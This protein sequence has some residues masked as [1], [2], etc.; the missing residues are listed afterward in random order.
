MM[1]RILTILVV[2]FMMLGLASSALAQEYYFA[3]PEE[4]VH[5]YWNE[6]GTLSLD[7]TF[8]FANQPGAHVIDFVDVGLPNSSFDFGSI[9][10]DVNGNAVSISRDY[11][12]SGSGV[13]VD[14][15]AHAIQPGQTGIVRVRVGLISKVLYTDSEIETDASAVFSPTWFG[16]QYVTGSTDLTVVF[17]LP[18]GVLPEEPRWHGAPSGFPTEP[19]TA[20]DDSGRVTYTWNN[21][22]ANAYTQYKFGASFPKNYVP[23]DVIQTEPVFQPPSFDF[24]NLMVPCFCAIWALVFFGAPVMGIVQA[25]RRKMKYLPPKISIEGHGIKR[26]LTAVEAAILMEQPLDKIMTMILFGVIKKNAAEVGSRDPLSLK[27]NETQPE[28]LH[29]YEKDFLSAF[30]PDINLKQRRL[31]LQDMTIRLVKSVSEKMKG[32]SRKETQAYYKNI[33]ERAWDQIAAAGTP[34]VQSKLYEEALEWTMLDKDYDDRTRRTFTGPVIVPTWWGRYDPVYRPA[35]ASASPISTGAPS[36]GSRPS[37]LP[38]ADFAASMVGGVQ[39]FSQKVIGNVGD[40]T[41]RVTGVT[42]PPPKTT[43]RSGGGGGGGG[44]ACAC[45]CAGCACACAGGGR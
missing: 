24:E 35:S 42:N 20:L 30:R 37:G 1:R 14:L 13:A 18:S 9:S 12:G 27:I 16:S 40:F 32:F 33:M 44:C 23:A 41:N 21:P 25:Q 10:A 4:T 3:V 36:S 26:G 17:H 19:A 43:Y 22:N 11:Q 29:Q 2:L 8:V 5:V 15:G 38:G 31:D 34:E 6:N 39:T 7:Y 45:A 28:G